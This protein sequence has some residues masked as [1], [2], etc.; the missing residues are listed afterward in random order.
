MVRLKLLLF[1]LL[2][3]VGMAHGQEVRVAAAASLNFAMRELEAAFEAAHPGISITVQLGSSANFFTQLQQGLPI[4]LF[5]SANAEYPRLLYEL[6]LAEPGTRRLYAV[7]RL[8][9]WV[10]NSLVAQGLD[11]RA[12][13][14]DLLRDPRVTQLAIANPVH[15]PYGRAGVTLLEHYGLL[16][17]T[18][19]VAW[20][21]MRMGIPGY[22]DLAPLAQG[23]HSFDF[24]YGNNVAQAAQLATV[25]GVGLIAYSLALADDL[26][27]LGEFWLAPIE[28]HLRLDKEVIILT[29]QARPEVKAFYEFVF[30]PQG[31]DIWQR[32]GFSLPAGGS[33]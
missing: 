22:F 19:E 12:L 9:L 31:R 16:K 21:E 23:K 15:A 5:F 28:S 11:P 8:A 14:I 17:R 4:D 10:H 30:S 7:G 29:G 1:V 24:V 6:G 18:R 32:Y 27:R 3:L 33:P 13:G 25:T 20:R 26:S 2:G